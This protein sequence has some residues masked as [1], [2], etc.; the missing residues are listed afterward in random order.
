MIKNGC[1]KKEKRDEN[2]LW[3]YIEK[4]QAN[5]LIFPNHA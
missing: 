1:V 3:K 2:G 5:K 4:A